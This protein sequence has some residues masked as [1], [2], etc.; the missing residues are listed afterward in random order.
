MYH[1][2][3]KLIRIFVLLLLT[4]LIP[5]QAQNP[6][7]LLTGSEQTTSYEVPKPNELTVKWWQEAKKNAPVEDPFFQLKQLSASLEIYQDQATYP[8]DNVALKSISQFQNNLD[9]IINL[10]EVETEAENIVFEKQDAYS[11]DEIYA[12]KKMVRDSEREKIQRQ[13]DINELRNNAKIQYQAIDALIIRHRNLPKESLGKLETGL[14]W[15][16]SRSWMA[17]Y[18]KQADLLEVKQADQE[19]QLSDLNNH[20]E[21]AINLIQPDVEKTASLEKAL[22]SLDAQIDEAD[23]QVQSA[24]IRITLPETDD[25]LGSLQTDVKKLELANNMLALNLL[26]LEQIQKKAQLDWLDSNQPDKALDD[27]LILD[28]VNKASE[29][30]AMSEANLDKW[31]ALA[32]DILIS[33]AINSELKANR[34]IKDAASKRNRL[35]QTLLLSLDDLS[36]QQ[37]RVS[38]IESL[39]T[40][41]V[42]N[43]KDGI[44]R[45]WAQIKSYSSGVWFGFERLANQTLFK[46]NETPITLMPLLRL[47][48]IVLIGYLVSKLVR[49]VLHRVESRR[50]VEKSSVFFILDKL[51]HYM[52][53]FIATIAGFTT[54]GID[55]TNLTLIAGALSVGIGFGL[56]NIVSNFVSGLTIMFERSLKVGDYIEMEDGYTGS[57]MEINARSTR[58][59]TNDNID[60]VIPNSDL[61]TNKI[62]N[63]TL[64][65]SIK[66]VKIPFGVAYG[67]DKEKVKAAAIEAAENVSYTLTNMKGKE[68][69]VWMKGFGDNSLDFILLVWVSKYGVRRPNRIKASFLWELD[70]AFNKYGIEVPFPQRVIHYADQPADDELEAENEGGNSQ[71]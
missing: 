39:L 45:L 57:V 23:K 1:T 43:S 31:K 62:I 34:K 40:K 41:Q 24:N 60:V 17:L 48:V 12:I 28:H 64:R 16:E 19:K 35:A 51:I 65:D 7:D 58:I 50:K 27:D 3:D 44:N 8:I 69:E 46:I 63:W 4:A 56:Q 66:R 22:E 37:E 70:T 42:I 61:V 71:A 52:I 59:N 30:L 32:Q 13:D 26:Q 49:F 2:G 11:L 18:E 6:L 33:P 67:T 25:L 54:L 10:S 68:P 14:Q 47:I 5:A 36:W 21:D 29:L 55:F 20:L 15:I 53:I 9:Q 38:F